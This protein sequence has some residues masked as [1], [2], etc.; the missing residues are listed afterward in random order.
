MAKIKIKANGKEYPVEDGLTIAEF[1]E[2]TGANPRRCV[3]EQNLKRMRYETF[4]EVRL[5][6]GDTIEVMEIVAGG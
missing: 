2:S 5:R 4:A 3:V 6:D 1:I